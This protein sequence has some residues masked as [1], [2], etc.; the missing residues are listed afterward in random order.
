MTLY[1]HDNFRKFLANASISYRSL[2]GVNWVNSQ[3]NSVETRNSYLYSIFNYVYTIPPTTGNG[4]QSFGDCWLFLSSSDL[5]LTN[6]N[7]CPDIL[8]N[9]SFSSSVATVTPN[10]GALDIS[11]TVTNTDV[12][13]ITI[14]KM[15]VY[16]NG[17]GGAYNSTK[18]S[19][20]LFYVVD[21]EGPVILAPNTTKTLHFSLDFSNL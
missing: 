7:D 9:V 10:N 5:T 3:G 20:F 21:L 16:K 8:S 17:G 19:Y 11:F 6:E 15:A 1:I 4:N 12:G 2:E 18:Q 13:D 14:R